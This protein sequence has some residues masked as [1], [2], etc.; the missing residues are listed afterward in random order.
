[1]REIY[2]QKMGMLNR[3]FVY[4]FPDFPRLRNWVWPL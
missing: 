2:T 1:M 3:L 4:D